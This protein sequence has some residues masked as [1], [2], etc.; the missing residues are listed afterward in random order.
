MRELARRLV[1]F[2]LGPSW[3]KMPGIAAAAL[4]R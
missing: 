4:R 3:L 1:E 2:E